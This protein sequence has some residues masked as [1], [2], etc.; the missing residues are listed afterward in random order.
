MEW[1]INGI[2]QKAREKTASYS[3]PFYVG[4]YKCQVFIEWDYNNTGKVACFVRIMK[5]EFDDKLKWSFIYRRKFVLLNQNRNGENYIRSSEITQENLQKYPAS[6]QKPTEIMN[7][8]FGTL[9][10]ISNTVI[11]KY[12]KNDSIYLHITVEQLPAF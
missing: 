10:F 5:G 4:L 7:I 12:C 2:K 9:S 11:L 8:G 3:D 1:K 6:F